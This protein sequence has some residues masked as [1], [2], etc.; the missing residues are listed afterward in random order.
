MTPP[1]NSMNKDTNRLSERSQSWTST[2][3]LIPSAEVLEQARLIYGINNQNC[4]CLQEGWCGPAEVWGYTPGWKRTLSVLMGP[5]PPTRMKISKLNKQD[6]PDLWN[7]QDANLQKWLWTTANCITLKCVGIKGAGI[8]KLQVI[9]KK[10]EIRDGRIYGNANIAECYKWYNLDG[11]HMNAHC[12]FPPTFLH[13]WKFFKIKCQKKLLYW[14][15]DPGKS[16][17]GYITLDFVR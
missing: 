1:R 10:G 11:G 16:V 5:G 3:S 14:K 9:P 7:L 2:D 13:D 6:T 17:S 8:Q 15:M 12:V 4:G